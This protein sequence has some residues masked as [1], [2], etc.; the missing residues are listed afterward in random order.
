[1]EGKLIACYPRLGQFGQATIIRF[2]IFANML[3][4]I[5]RIYIGKQGRLI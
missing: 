3:E 4:P 2:I 1:M 5:G